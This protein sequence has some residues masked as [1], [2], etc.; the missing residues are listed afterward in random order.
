L[1][2]SALANVQAQG[3]RLLGPGA[4]GP[5]RWA[6]RDLTPE[7]QAQGLSLAALASHLGVS[8]TVAAAMIEGAEKLD[9]QAQKV[10]A[11]YLRADPRDLFTDMPPPGR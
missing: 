7:L 8:E 5:D 3:E 9:A 10:A 2:E 1:S 11:I 4:A 6:R